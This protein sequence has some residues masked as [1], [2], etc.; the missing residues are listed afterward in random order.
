M[1]FLV[2]GF[3]G[4]GGLTGASPKSF[5]V[6]SILLAHWVIVMSLP[7]LYSV[8][9]ADSARLTRLFLPTRSDS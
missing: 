7:S 3:G 2:M 6:S 1:S 9:I 4:S 5:T 8:R